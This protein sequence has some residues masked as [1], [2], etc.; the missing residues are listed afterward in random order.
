MNRVIVA[1][2]VCLVLVGAG[3]RSL[4]PAT[5]VEV[6]PNDIGRTLVLSTGHSLVV[7]LP[8]NPT[9]G[10]S[11]AVRSSTAAVLRANGEEYVASAPERVG[12]GGTQRLTFVA[13]SVGRTSLTF[14]Y[15]RPWEAGAAPAQVV[16]YVVSVE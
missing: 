8:A 10:Y 3:C 13:A 12:S 4:S 14:E 5:V 7:T 6:G 16:E 2:I 15:R 1:T 11:W 9:T